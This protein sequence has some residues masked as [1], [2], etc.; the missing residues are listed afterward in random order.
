VRAHLVNVRREELTTKGKRL[1]KRAMFIGNLSKLIFS[2]FNNYLTIQKGGFV[3]ILNN[4]GQMS[5]KAEKDGGNIDFKPETLDYLVASSDGQKVSGQID[6]Q[7][8]RQVNP[9]GKPPYSVKMGFGDFS[10]SATKEGVGASD[11][12][13][14]IMIW[15]TGTHYINYGPQ[16]FLDKSE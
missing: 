6:P 11:L 9:T 16:V 4:L 1:S 13:S 5:I 3:M 14:F 8:C 2:Q 10:Y 7:C 15:P 12:V